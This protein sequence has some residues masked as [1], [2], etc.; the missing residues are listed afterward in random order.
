MNDKKKRGAAWIAAEDAAWTAYE[1][2]CEAAS[3]SRLGERHAYQMA[4]DWIVASEAAAEAAAAYA[5]AAEAA[6]RKPN[7]IL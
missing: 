3:K 1:T 7:E 2:A 5:A 6:R 4:G